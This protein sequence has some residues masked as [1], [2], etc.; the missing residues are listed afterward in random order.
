MRRRILFLGL[1]VG[2]CI[3]GL[4]AC[5]SKEETIKETTENVTEEVTVSEPT[6]TPSP[7]PSPELT[8][9]PTSEPVPE[10]ETIYIVSKEI[11]YD[12]DGKVSSVTTYEYDVYGNMTAMNTDGR[13]SSRTE[14]KYEYDENG[15]IAKCVTL[16]EDGLIVNISTYE[17]DAAGNQIKRGYKNESLGSEGEEISEYDTDN[18]L[19]K[20]TDYDEDGTIKEIYLYEY[21]ND[22]LI[23]FGS[24]N[25]DGSLNW[26]SI[27]E[28]DSDGRAIKEVGS[29]SID[30]VIYSS[31]G[32]HEYDADGNLIKTYFYDGDEL[33]S[34][35][36]YENNDNGKQTKCTCHGVDGSIYYIE[37]TEYIEL[38][39]KQAGK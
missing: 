4:V 5:G 24:Y 8:A 23:K 35:K 20:I 10:T 15:N 9:E 28:Y 1:V 31:K 11:A 19:M 17:Y 29:I 30:G 33:A 22:M 38:E 21:D 18:N 7:E 16:D 25:A 32:E 26:D 14:Y 6:E 13:F 37:E 12:G 27:Y 34:W 3:S 2:L 36:E 39:V